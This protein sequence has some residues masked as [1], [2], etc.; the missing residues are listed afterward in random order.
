MRS[1]GCPYGHRTPIFRSPVVAI[2]KLGVKYIPCT[3]KN[4]NCRLNFHAELGDARIAPDA[5]HAVLENEVPYTVLSAEF[6][7]RLMEYGQGNKADK[8]F[9]LRELSD[10][11]EKE[12]GFHCPRCR[13][14]SGQSIR[15]V[16]TLHRNAA[17]SA[18]MDKKHLG[19]LPERN[20]KKPVY[21]TLLIDPAW[22]AGSPGVAE[23]G[24]ELGGYIDAPVEATEKWYR[25]RLKNLRLIEARGTVGEASAEEGQSQTLP[26]TIALPSGKILH[27]SFGTM[28]ADGEFVCQACGQ[29][30]AALA[31]AEATGKVLP[32]FPYAIQ[33]Y[34]PDRDDGQRPY[35]G[36]FFR[37]PTESDIQKVLEACRDWATQG[38]TTLSGF[39]PTSGIP[40]GNRTHVRDPIFRHGYTHWSRMF[41]A[42]QL[43]GLATLNRA[44]QA[45]VV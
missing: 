43:F 1:L 27:T 2:K 7:K 18:D 37:A 13:T 36:R 35:G 23:D 5:E 4:K 40:Y 39:W 45:L 29:R 10:L 24:T 6:T 41:N 26:E 11:V 17:R 38:S 3:C 31:A 8:E 16:L 28:P 21:C 44:I 20:G 14:W 15:D 34:E 19:I 25:E 42:R 33:A 22:L 30:N 9:R 12:P 32:E